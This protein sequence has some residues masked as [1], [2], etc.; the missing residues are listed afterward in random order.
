MNT[1]VGKRTHPKRHAGKNRIGGPGFTL[2]EILIGITILAVGLLGIAGMFS[3]AY[4]DINAGGKTTMAVT[5]ARQI[6][7]DMRLMPFA[8]LV[9]VN[10][11]D[12]NTVTSQPAGQPELAM[13]RKWRYLVA[14]SGTGWNFTAAE[15]AE[16]KTLY[17]GG[18]NFGGQ[19][20]V[21]VTSPSPTL[22]LVTVTVPL[23]GRTQGTVLNISLSTLISRL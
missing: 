10:G 23:Q 6:I 8:N 12:T 19:A 15:M 2:I 7:E 18:A 9:N 5:A 20:T 16:W 13:A 14:G 4:V 1:P 22:R 17:T 3:T 21:A 11:F